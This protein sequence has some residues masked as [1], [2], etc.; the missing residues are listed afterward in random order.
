MK[1]TAVFIVIAVLSLGLTAAGAKTATAPQG[2]NDRVAGTL[3]GPDK[4]LKTTSPLA[5]AGD[6]T[7]QPSKTHLKHSKIRQK[8]PLHDPN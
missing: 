2:D 4:G 5:P 1:P 7:A 3:A 8:P 6:S